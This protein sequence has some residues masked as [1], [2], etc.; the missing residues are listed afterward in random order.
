MK[1]LPDCAKCLRE[2]LPAHGFKL[3]S[4]TW[5]RDV[6][7][8]V[9]VV[10]F[11]RGKF[12]SSYLVRFG[13]L[14]KSVFEALWGK[15]PPASPPAYDCTVE[16]GRADLSDSKSW[17]IDDPT[18][19]AEIVDLVRSSALPFFDQMHS[20]E[21]QLRY[22]TQPDYINYWTKPLY[23]AILMFEVGDREAAC[24]KLRTHTWR[25]NSK[26]FE[27]TANEI[28]DRLNCPKL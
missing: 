3:K 4:S 17:E 25:V 12:G 13:V 26:D 28:A 24:K 22:I 19:A 23:T 21:A 9:D 15:A 10:G 1:R 14:T 7:E 8:F 16:L 5:R 2:I 18:A 11:E 20:R 6:G 27:E